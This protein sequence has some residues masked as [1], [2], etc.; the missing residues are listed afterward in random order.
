MCQDLAL[1]LGTALRASHWWWWKRCC[2]T[3]CCCSLWSCPSACRDRGCTGCGAHALSETWH[4]HRPVGEPASRA[5]DCAAGRLVAE[6]VARVESAVVRAHGRGG[7]GRGR[8][9][10]QRARVLAA[11]ERRERR[12]EP[13]RAPLPVHPRRLRRIFASLRTL[14]THA[15]TCENIRFSSL[16]SCVSFFLSFRIVLWGVTVLARHHAK[17]GWQVRERGRVS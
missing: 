15:R 8:R 11:A 12:H 2:C 5:V 10:A 9:A 6:Q 13:Q 3:C 14:R 17:G 7:R 16:S 1:A 4:G